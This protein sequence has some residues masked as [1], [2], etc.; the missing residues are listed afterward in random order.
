MKCTIEEKQL[1]T[2]SVLELY[3]VA[4]LYHEVTSEGKSVFTPVPMYGL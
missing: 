4:S 1:T 2:V 3:E